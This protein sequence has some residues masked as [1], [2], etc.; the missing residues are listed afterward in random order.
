MSAGPLSYRERSR[1]IE[2][3]IRVSYENMLLMER[4]GQSDSALYWFN[5]MGEYIRQRSPAKVAEM[6]ARMGLA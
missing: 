1:D 6:E 3:K 5:R 2:D 4:I